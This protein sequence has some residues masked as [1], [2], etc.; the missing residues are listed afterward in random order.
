M[1]VDSDKLGIQFNKFWSARTV[2]QIP[3]KWYR[4]INTVHTTAYH[5]RYLVSGTWCTNPKGRDQS[6]LGRFISIFGIY[7]DKRMNCTLKVLGSKV[8]VSFWRCRGST[9]GE[10]SFSCRYFVA[11][12]LCS[13]NGSNLADSFLSLLFSVTATWAKLGTNTWKALHSLKKDL[14]SITVTGNSKTRIALDVSDSISKRF[15]GSACPRNWSKLWKP[16]I[17]Q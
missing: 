4:A 13:C 2:Y 3:S 7:S 15:G 17:F 12:T 9:T 10:I 16:D 6:I 5:L 11:T 8:N 1:S 14:S